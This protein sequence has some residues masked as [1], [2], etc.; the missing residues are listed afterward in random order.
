MA[1]VGR[2][3]VVVERARHEAACLLGVEGDLIPAVG[4]QQVV[5]G[6]V[7]HVEAERV[8]RAV[9]LAGDRI[10]AERDQVVAK[11][12]IVQRLSARSC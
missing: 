7:L 1:A 5:G 12:G 4:V 11:R 9:L 8:Q 3:R 10:E 6:G 2:R